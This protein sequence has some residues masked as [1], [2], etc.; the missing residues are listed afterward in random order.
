MNIALEDSPTKSRCAFCF[1]GRSPSLGHLGKNW[2][3]AVHTVIIMNAAEPA[4]Q[5]HSGTGMIFRS[6]SL[7]LCPSRSLSMSLCVA[8]PTKKRQLL[9]MCVCFCTYTLCMYVC[10]YTHLHLPSQ[11]PSLQGQPSSLVPKQILQIMPRLF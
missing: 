7:A 11:T 1:G 10:I 9:H 8:Q 3:P 4:Y 6:T 2:H 5:R